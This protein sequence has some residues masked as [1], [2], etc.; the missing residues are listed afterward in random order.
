MVRSAAARNAARP[1]RALGISSAGGKFG[2][3]TAPGSEAA[4]PRS[5][6]ATLVFAVLGGFF[7]VH[8]FYVGKPL[9]G[10]LMPFTLG[11]FG[12]WWLADIVLVAIGEFTDGDGR[13]VLH[14][15]PEDRLAAV[16]ARQDPRL[17]EE[18]DRLRGDVYELQE[19]VDFLERTLAQV[20]ERPGLGRGDA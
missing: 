17:T 8:R 16:G 9:S 11:G 15:T 3:M 4:S 6:A 14:W 12:L 2:R 19:R 7:G 20:R 5:R 10:L 18:V 1:S 13:R